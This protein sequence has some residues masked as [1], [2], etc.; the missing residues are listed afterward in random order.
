MIGKK[1]MIKLAGNLLVVICFVLCHSIPAY[2]E[3]NGVAK[4][5]T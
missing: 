4:Y 3:S 2:A 5:W 1:S